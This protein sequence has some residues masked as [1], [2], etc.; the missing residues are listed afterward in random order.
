MFLYNNIKLQFNKKMCR[1][2]G[3]CSL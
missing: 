3:V 2:Q 1:K